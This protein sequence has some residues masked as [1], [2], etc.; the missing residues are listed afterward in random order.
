M[1]RKNC[2]GLGIAFIFI[3]FCF[4]LVLPLVSAIRINEGMYNPNSTQ[5]GSSNEWVELY[6]ANWINLSNYVLIEKQGNSNRTSNLSG[7]FDAGSYLIIANNLSK[8]KENW[9]LSNVFEIKLSLS[10]EGD[11]IWIYMNNTL[12]DFF[13]YTSSM[14]ANGNGKSLQFCNGSWIEAE[15]TPGTE[16]LCQS[17]TQTNQNQ[18][19]QTSQNQTA[20]AS[21]SLEL[22]HEKEFYSNNEIE[23]SVKAY[24]LQNYDYDLKVYFSL[25]NGTLI[26]EIYNAKEKE[27]VS[28]NYYLNNITAGEG[29]KTKILKLRLRQG[30]Q[31]FS[32]NVEITAKIRKTETTN[33]LAS[34]LGNI[35]I[36]KQEQIPQQNTT[37]IISINPAAGQNSSII[38]LGKAEKTKDIKSQN[39]NDYK[40]K[41]QYIKEYSIYF[42]ALFCVFVVIILIAKKFR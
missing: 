30:Y 7:S 26:S 2:R 28:G 9:N 12:I 31:N 3:V 41:T 34:I 5:G 19:N 6:F 35:K 36:I 20:N 32:G 11:S 42:F 13:N 37:S 8:F 24:N 17:Q 38:K 40:S 29:N 14:G 15:P 33:I 39:S 21:I 1:W 10:N 22:S 25:D 27:W 16:N 4:F 23:V 18:T